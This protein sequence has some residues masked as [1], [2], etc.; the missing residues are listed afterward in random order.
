MKGFVVQIQSP[1][2]QCKLN[3]LNDSSPNSSASY[4]SSPKKSQHQK[5]QFYVEQTSHKDSNSNTSGSL[6]L[7]RES[8]P[9]ANETEYG[10]KSI[11]QDLDSN[12]LLFNV[13]GYNSVKTLQ[14]STTVLLNASLAKKIDYADS[15]N[16]KKR[17]E[18]QQSIPHTSDLMGSKKTI[19]NNSKNTIPSIDTLDQNN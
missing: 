17:S 7:S 19:F 12:K 4:H 16:F 9:K 11:S 1:T 18:E 2:E 3:F 8:I 15:L 14:R 13:S 5:S 6:H 10:N